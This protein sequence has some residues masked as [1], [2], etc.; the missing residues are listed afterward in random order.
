MGP[1]AAVEWRHPGR[2]SELESLRHLLREQAR[3]A[4]P[5]A[6]LGSCVWPGIGNADRMLSPKLRKAVREAAGLG[7]AGEGLDRVGW[8]GFQAHRRSARA[9]ASDQLWSTATATGAIQESRVRFKS[10]GSRS[11][12]GS[13]RFSP[14]PVE[15]PSLKFG[16]R[17]GEVSTRTRME[18]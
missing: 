6:D 2:P 15:G 1:Q 11:L 18:A 16:G 13:V 12:C 14:G 9:R 17:Q 7:W 3:A 5:G 4:R 8:M 10:Q